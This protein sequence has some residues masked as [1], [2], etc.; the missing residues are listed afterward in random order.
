MN[1]YDKSRHFLGLVT[2]LASL[3]TILVSLGII[4]YRNELFS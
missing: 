3:G 2:I 4:L 1:G